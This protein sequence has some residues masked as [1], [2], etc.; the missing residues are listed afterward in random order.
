M[1][2]HT[3]DTQKGKKQVLFSTPKSGPGL[4]SGFHLDSLEVNQGSIESVV[5]SLSSGITSGVSLVVLRWIDS[6][7]KEII[8]HTQVPWRIIV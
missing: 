7:G 3:V 6:F 8:E 1:K 5:T 4:T 2:K